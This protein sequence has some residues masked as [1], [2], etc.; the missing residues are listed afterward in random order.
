MEAKKAGRVGGLQKMAGCMKLIRQYGKE[1]LGLL[2]DGGK[3][4]V[5]QALK[6]LRGAQEVHA[7][8]L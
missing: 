1:A 5:E 6:A 8:R 3:T 4:Y 2:H 7:N